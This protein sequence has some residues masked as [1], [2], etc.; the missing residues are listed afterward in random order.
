MP[1]IHIHLLEGREPAV[2][3]ACI[4]GVARAVHQSLGAPLETIRVFATTVPAAYWAAGDETKE[5][6]AAA[7]NSASAEAVAPK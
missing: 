3:S 2:V 6:Q 4:K 1:I 5:E 7:R